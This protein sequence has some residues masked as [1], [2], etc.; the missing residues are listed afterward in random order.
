MHVH[1][2]ASESETHTCRLHVVEPQTFAQRGPQV[3]STLGFDL[4]VEEQKQKYAY[5]A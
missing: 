3:H 1:K 4:R 5:I 2:G